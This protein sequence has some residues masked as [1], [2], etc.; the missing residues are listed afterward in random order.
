MGAHGDDVSSRTPTAPQ[1]DSGLPPG[2]EAAAHVRRP[3]AV[4]HALAEL[5]AVVAARLAQQPLERRTPVV[6]DE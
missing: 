6:S 3:D 5:V 2:A 4:E 1:P